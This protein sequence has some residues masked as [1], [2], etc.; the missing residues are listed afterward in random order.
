[1][2]GLFCILSA[3]MLFFIV[4]SGYCK[5][6]IDKKVEIGTSIIPREYLDIIECTDSVVWYLLDPMSEDTTAL[7]LGNIA[8]VLSCRTDTISK[9]VDLFRNTLLNPKSFVVSN[10][11]KECTFLPDV[12]ACLYSN[13]GTLYFYYSFYCDL[14]RLVSGEKYKEIDGELIRKDVLRMVCDIFPTDRYFRNLN[15]REK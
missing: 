9:R 6:N 14:C 1:M 13:K 15:R 7:R 10:M 11:V 8:E 12:A 3:F 2:K 4:D 5:L